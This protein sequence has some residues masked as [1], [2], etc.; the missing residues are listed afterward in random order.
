MTA[1]KVGRDENVEAAIKR[2]LNKVKKSGLLDEIQ[3]RKYFKKPS[4]KRNEDKRRRK[5][6]MKKLKDEKASEKD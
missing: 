6:V 2:F 4:V 1:V 5:R 3:E